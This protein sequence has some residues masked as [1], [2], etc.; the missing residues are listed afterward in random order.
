MILQ[1]NYQGLKKSARTFAHQKFFSLEYQNE[2]IIDFFGR[3]EQLLS[4]LI[5]TGAKMDEVDKVNHLI[6]LLPTDYQMQSSNWDDT[7]KDKSIE[8]LIAYLKNI[9]LRDIANNKS[10]NSIASFANQRVNHR[11][12]NS[13]EGRTR[14]SLENKK[15]CTYCKKQGHELQKCY[16]LLNIKKEERRSGSW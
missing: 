8:N 12:K 13:Q 9:D 10:K 15:V 16:K 11:A 2:N 3:F 14:N 7:S 4:T 6:S 5:L 1:S